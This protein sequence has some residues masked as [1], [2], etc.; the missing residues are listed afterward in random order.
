[1][2][3]KAESAIGTDGQVTIRDMAEL[4]YIAKSPSAYEVLVTNYELNELDFTALAISL[5]DKSESLKH[6]ASDSKTSLTPPSTPV[7]KKPVL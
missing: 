1:L 6:N 4:L 3:F 5:R 7:S 2:V